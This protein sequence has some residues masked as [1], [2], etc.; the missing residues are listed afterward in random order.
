MQLPSPPLDATLQPRYRN[1]LHRRRL[2][3]SQPFELGQRQCVSIRRGEL[4]EQRC[5]AGNKFL[6]GSRVIS[7]KVRCLDGVELCIGPEPFPSSSR[8]SVVV[9]DAVARYLVDPSM[10][11]VLVLDS[12]DSFMDTNEDILHDVVD[13]GRVLDP[14]SNECP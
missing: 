10:D 4:V 12:V 9:E 14:S 1:L 5:E 7:V 11:T 8:R 2:S 3:L 13:I 6:D